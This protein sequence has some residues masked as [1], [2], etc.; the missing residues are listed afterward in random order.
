VSTAFSP[1]YLTAKTTV[2]TDGLELGDVV[3]VT[4]FFKVVKT[5][6]DGEGVV[7]LLDLRSGFANDVKIVADRQYLNVDSYSSAQETK[8]VPIA[9]IWDEFNKIPA[10]DVF[11]IE[12]GRPPTEEQKRERIREYH[13]RVEDKIEM[14]F[15]VN[16]LICNFNV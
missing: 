14:F 2:Q 10:N 16:T 6:A 3:G 11:V 15:S 5:S 13:R 8:Q 1:N 12:Y 7:E 4:S 9:V